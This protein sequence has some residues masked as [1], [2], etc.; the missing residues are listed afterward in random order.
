MAMQ[1]TN[2]ARSEAI[3]AVAMAAGATDGAWSKSVVS[4]RL[5]ARRKAQLARLA[6]SLPVGSPPSAAIDAAIERALA[7]PNALPEPLADRLEELE[8]AFEAAAR[9]IKAHARSRDSDAA[10]AARSS[11]AILALISVA[12]GAEDDAPA[13]APQPESIGPWL[14]RELRELRVVAKESAIA[15]AQWIGA[16][17]T[18]DWHAH[19]EFEA[20]LAAIDGRSLVADTSRPGPIETGPIAIDGDLFRAIAMHAAQPMFVALQ[21]SGLTW[22]ATLFASDSGGALAAKLGPLPLE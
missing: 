9:D 21:R 16:R 3:S 20:S 14:D 17:R 4:I 22:R 12:G 5:S 11:K 13:R 15:R 10:E 7:S 18:G 2:G 19:V 8:D 6:A 1:T